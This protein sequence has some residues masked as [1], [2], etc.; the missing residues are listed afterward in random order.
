MLTTRG[1]KISDR[2]MDRLADAINND[3]FPLFKNLVDDYSIDITTLGDHPKIKNKTGLCSKYID[4]FIYRVPLSA[5]EVRSAIKKKRE[6]LIK[7]SE[8]NS[9]QTREIAK[10]MLELKPNIQALEAQ[11]FSRDQKELLWLRETYN[12]YE[13][14][15][16]ELLGKLTPSEVEKLAPFK[17]LVE[18]CNAMQDK[19]FSLVFFNVEIMAKQELYIKTYREIDNDFLQDT[20]SARQSDNEESEQKAQP[21]SDLIPPSNAITLSASLPRRDPLPVIAEVPPL[22]TLAIQSTLIPPTQP[23]TAS[24]PATPEDLRGQERTSLLPNLTE[25]ANSNAVL[26]EVWNKELKITS[27]KELKVE[28]FTDYLKRRETN[29]QVASNGMITQI[30]KLSANTGLPTDNKIQDSPSEVIDDERTDVL[31]QP[32]LAQK[33]LEIV[34]NTISSSTLK[35]HGMF[36]KDRGAATPIYPAGPVK[37]QLPSSAS[38]ATSQPTATSISHAYTP[39]VSLDNTRD[40]RPSLLPLKAIRINDAIR[41]RI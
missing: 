25:S 28:E 2:K 32:S 17:P 8:A 22:H 33:D 19:S 3:D 21:I 11:H 29:Q 35:E 40:K 1:E 36:S 14:A 20:V 39:K 6:Q 24:T 26:E 30:L 5:R 7:D 9:V 37:I 12:K 10:R 16:K 18:E 41:S 34:R 23:V 13:I 38:S 15:K 4:F 27:S 31:S